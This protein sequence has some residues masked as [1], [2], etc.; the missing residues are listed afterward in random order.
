MKKSGLLVLVFTLLFTLVAPLQTTK[1]EAAGKKVAVLFSE[2]S[3]KY[4]GE[5]RAGGSL[6]GATISPKEN[7]SS[8]YDKELKMYHL[9]KEQG[10]DVEKITDQDLSNLKKLHQ[11]EAVVFPYTVMMNHSQREGVKNYIRDG[12][13]A[14]FA[15]GTARNEAAKYP[16]RGQLDLSAL[17]YDTETWVWEW[18]NLSEVFHSAFNDDVVLKNYKV[19]SSNEQHPILTAAYKDLGKKSIELTNTRS[20]G[21]WIEVIEPWNNAV[22]PLLVYSDYSS[23]S[24]PTFTTKNKTGAL[25]AFEHGK[26]RVVFTGFKMYDHFGVEAEGNWDA[27]AMGSAYDGTT[28]DRDAQAVFKSS[29]NWVMEETKSEKKRVYDLAMNFSNLRAYL[30]PR[31]YSVYGEMTIRNTGNVPARGTIRVDLVNA[32]GK[33][34]KSY[35]RYL[36]GLS[37]DKK[38]TSVHT[39][40]FHLSL[41]KNLAQGTYE[42]RTVFT[43]GRDDRPGLEVKAVAT[44]LVHRGGPAAFNTPAI[45]KDVSL[46]HEMIEDMRNG[47]HLGIIRGY[48]DGTFKPSNTVNRVQATEMMLRAL[49]VPISGSMT[50]PSSDLKKGQY[51]YAVLA[52]GVANGVIS[53]QNGKINAGGP[54]TRGDM[55]AGLVT[56]FKLQG[57]SKHVFKDVPTKH[58]HYAAVQVLDAQGITNGYKVDN[59]YRPNMPVTRAHFTAFINRSLK[60]SPQ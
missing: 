28:G 17:I 34:L 53:L 32:H 4:A 16:K 10:F 30:T 43:D 41:P 9:Y 21:D 24:N 42:L 37:P 31:D 38:Y 29:L 50:M 26:G 19:K 47:A 59:T 7:W 5:V 27:S 51:G 12:G 57:T 55:A 36:P 6:N 3:E 54:M 1:V 60:A 49:H 25:Y 56:G 18:D 39:E 52:T 35:E 23:S 8:I 48:K 13:G 45:F 14:I 15:Y 40:K 2:T 58:P 46:K 20:G 11:Y 22:K 44:N 33:V